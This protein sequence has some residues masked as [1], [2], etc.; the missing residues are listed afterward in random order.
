MA[1]AARRICLLGWVLLS[2]GLPKLQAAVRDVRTYG[3]TGNGIT[4]DSA[5]LYNA[6]AA[7]VPGD[8]LLF[9]CGTY[10]TTAELVVSVSH[11][12]IDGSGCATIHNVGSS[13]RLGIFVVGGNATTDPFYGPAVPLSQA[14]H[15]LD[16]SFTTV[17][18]PGVSPGDY[19]YIHQGGLD[20]STDTPPGHPTGCDVSAC[21]GEVLKVQ[22]VDGNTITVT[23]ALHDTYDPVVN[24]AVVQ[25][26]LD[27]VTGVTVK[28][29]T[30]E[31]TQAQWLGFEMNGVV[32]SEVR[33]VTARNVQGPAIH[34]S[35]S[36]NLSYRHITV[37]QA[38]SEA[39]GN[40]VNL[41]VGGNMSVHKMTISNENPGTGTGCLGGGAFGF[42]L[43]AVAD[44]KFDHVTVDASGAYGRPFK[45]VAARWNTFD[46]VRVENGAGDGNGINLEYY[47][48]HNT[49]NRCLVINNSAGTGTGNGNAGIISFGNFNQ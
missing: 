22:S 9:S 25:K 23:T 19:I 40:A 36:F 13:G 41:F 16:T 12:T 5:A 48:S 38:G 47:S 8:T 37:T 7:L 1:G 24:A 10:L 2:L 18:D 39:C 33:D 14:A 4:D 11:V 43:Y 21:R 49:F 42:G 26:M 15:E 29:I 34:S 3:A 6:I 45:T 44:S 31:G 46:S 28:H 20:Y 32:D 17:S 27:P 30:F 35:G